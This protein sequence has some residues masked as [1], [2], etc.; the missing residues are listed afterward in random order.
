MERNEV[1]FCGPR[2]IYVDQVGSIWKI[3]V[4]YRF[5]A[6]YRPGLLIKYYFCV[7]ILKATAKDIP[8]RLRLVFYI[9]F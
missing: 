5:R 2:K 4:E 8:N 6:L 9:S 1:D 7:S 3:Y